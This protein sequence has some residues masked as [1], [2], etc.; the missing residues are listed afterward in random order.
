MPKRPFPFNGCSPLQLKTHVNAFHFEKANHMD[1]IYARTREL[2]HE[3]SLRLKKA[4][5]IRKATCRWKKPSNVKAVF[6]P[7]V[8]CVQRASSAKRTRVTIAVDSVHIVLEYSAVCVQL[9]TMMRDMND[10]FALDV[11]NNRICQMQDAISTGPGALTGLIIYLKCLFATDRS[12]KY[13]VMNI[14]MYI[15]KSFWN[16]LRV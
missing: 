15:I 7:S 3:G 8:V 10:I 16:W 2:M 9:L 12:N 13:Y 1:S 4:Q 6:S 5:A 11:H 14:I